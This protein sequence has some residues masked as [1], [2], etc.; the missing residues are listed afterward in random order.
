MNH[1]PF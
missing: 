1:I